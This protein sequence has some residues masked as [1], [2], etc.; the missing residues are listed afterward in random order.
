MDYLDGVV[1]EHLFSI[2]DIAQANHWGDRPEVRAMH[3][4]L[5]T[6]PRCQLHGTVSSL[7]FDNIFF[8]MLWCLTEGG[9]SCL[10]G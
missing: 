5:K 2:I 6:L 1:Q 9:F 4:E 8:L 10:L 7:F 3:E